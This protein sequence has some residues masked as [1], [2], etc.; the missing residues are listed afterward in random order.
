MALEHSDASTPVNWLGG[1]PGATRI[2]SRGM[3]KLR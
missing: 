1:N 3:A 2:L